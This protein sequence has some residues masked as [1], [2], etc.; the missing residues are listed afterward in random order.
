MIPIEG[1]PTL[2]ADE[3][4]AAEQAAMAEGTTEAALMDRAG[5]AIAEAIF[6][7][8]AT[9]E[10]LILCGP[11]NNGGDGYIA[12]A[13]LAERGKAV[14]VATASE[15]Q[16]DGCRQA[17]ARWQGP[18]ESLARAPSAPVLV[19]ALFGTGPSRG[20]EETT[21]HHL[22]RLADKAELRIAVDLPSGVAT[23]SGQVLSDIP[24]FDVTLALGAVKPAHLLQPSASHMGV[25]RVLDIGVPVGG[26][27]RVTTSPG[28]RE[29][30]AGSHKYSRGMVAIVAGS[31]S[32]ASELAAIAAARAGAGYVLHLAADTRVATAH[33]HAIVRRSFTPE[34][35]ND[36][37]IGAVVI[38][39]GL[40]R[41]ED[42]GERL[43]AAMDSGRPLVIDG[44]A[45]RLVD[46][47]ALAHHD[48]PKIL[49]PHGGEFLHLFGD[50]TADKLTA[51]RDAARRSRAIVVYKGADTVIAEP[52]GRAILCPSA[53]PW[54]STAGTGDVLAGAIGAMLAAG[55][56]PMAAAEAGVWLHGQAA[57]LCG[58]A[59]IA[60]DLADALSAVRG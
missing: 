44:D 1:R 17:A 16:S 46:L 23:D 37:R 7:L 38:G 6:R 12:A 56:D 4:R 3:M 41:D 31:M 11:G 53:S 45:L 59:F 14:R 21:A 55:L 60:D 54:L 25:V 30:D 35:L 50:M 26:T 22:R 51:T 9:R 32:G 34:A 15:P 39:P 27:A 5:R 33:P 18:V 40:G 2:T 52:G 58:K 19:D 47:D 43:R 24:C 13:I 28:L 57:R 10:V 42:A 8:A 36:A 20:L 29:P 48:G 49:T